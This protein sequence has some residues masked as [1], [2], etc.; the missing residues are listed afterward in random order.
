MQIKL[1]SKPDKDIPPKKMV[2]I[3]RGIDLKEINKFLTNT[4]NDINPPEVFGKELMDA[5]V[6]LLLRHVVSED[7]VFVL[8]DCD[9]DGWTSAALII[10]YLYENFP[11]WTLNHLNWGLHE[12]KQHGLKDY[13]NKL[14]KSNYKLILIP[15][16]GSNDIDEIERLYNLGIDVLILDHHIVED[17]NKKPHAII[18]NS[19]YNY[20][21]KA[22]SGVGVVYKFCQ[23]ADTIIGNN[24]SDK[25]KDLVAVGLMAD[26]MDIRSL[27]TK[28]MMFPKSLQKS[29]QITP[30]NRN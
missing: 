13:I 14:E 27:E 20:P 16:A 3:N 7:D 22:L 28:E 9:P 11:A 25:F 21:N 26:M 2:C 24:S 4:V 15:D 8:V 1:Y 12:G 5:G 19:Q 23:Y 17:E 30:I 6:K 29:K 18:I 10:N